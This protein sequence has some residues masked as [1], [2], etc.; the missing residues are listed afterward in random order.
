[1]AELVLELPVSLLEWLRREAL[2]QLAPE[3][4]RKGHILIDH[5]LLASAGVRCGWTED[6]AAPAVE[7]ALTVIKA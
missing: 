1:V 3:A 5:L 2:V 7:P 6:P 4:A